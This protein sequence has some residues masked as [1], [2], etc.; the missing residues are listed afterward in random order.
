MNPIN[1][2]DTHT[3]SKFPE[4]DFINVSFSMSVTN[5]DGIYD[6]ALTNQIQ[7][8]LLWKDLH[9]AS[10]IF[11]TVLGTRKLFRVITAGELGIVNKATDPKMKDL[12]TEADRSAE[13]FILQRFYQVVMMMM[14][15][16]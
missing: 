11:F 8:Q 4:C 2:A 1:I 3:M 13:R 10:D 9:P 14:L 5:I 6:M 12:Q 15:K 16:A 7:S